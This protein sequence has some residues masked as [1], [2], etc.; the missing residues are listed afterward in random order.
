MQRTLDNCGLEPIVPIKA[1]ADDDVV[2]TDGETR[3]HKDV[4]YDCRGNA[5]NNEEDR[6]E[7]DVQAVEAVLEDVDALVT[8]YC[9]GNSDYPDAYFCCVNETSHAWPTIIKRWIEKHYG[10]TYGRTNFDDRLDEVIKYICEELD[11]AYDCEPYY[12]GNE[13][14]SYYGKGCCLWATAIGEHEE[15]IDIDS[16]PVL[17]TL[18][19]RG[20]L[21]DVLDEVKSDVYVSR[22]KKRVKKDGKY[23][24][25][26]RETYGVNDKYPCLTTS[27]LPGGAWH[28]VVDE[29]RMEELITEALNGS[30]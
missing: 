20:A 10:D 6:F 23:E 16:N 5:H 12:Q 25:V 24:E 13:Y 27:H 8:D 21:D 11:A 14:A 4:H 28:F 18:H 29:E 15:Q 22:N 19:D 1:H 26:G 2:C 3:K 9:T 30:V 17:K 7:A